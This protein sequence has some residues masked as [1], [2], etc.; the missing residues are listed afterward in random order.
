MAPRSKCYTPQQ[1][2]FTLD[3]Y[4]VCEKTTVPAALTVLCIDDEV[5]GLEVRRAVLE[6]AG[7]H[8][9]TAADGAEGLDLFFS[10]AVDAVVLDYNMPG[11]NGGEV[12]SAMRQRR[13]EVPILLLSA[14]VGLPREVA[15]LADLLLT[16]GEGPAELLDKVDQLLS[17][18]RTKRSV[19]AVE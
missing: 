4:P 10:H 12:A 1:S 11:M 14:Y 9:L 6:R 19:D 5:V 18:T 3:Y 8:V 13:P 7:Y 15:S 2:Y 16:K 17:A